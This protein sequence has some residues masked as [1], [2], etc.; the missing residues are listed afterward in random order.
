MTLRKR[1]GGG[2]APAGVRWGLLALLALLLGTLLALLFIPSPQVGVIRFSDLIWADSVTWLEAQFRYAEQDP[3]IRAIVIE[4]D[5]PGGE[6]AASERL[7]F[8]LLRLR[9]HKPVVVM[10][11]SMAASGGYYAAVAAD[12]IYATPSSDVGNIGVISTMPAPSFLVEDYLFTG[13]FK[14]FGSPRDSY[15]RQ[16]EVLKDTFIEGVFAQR[17]DRLAK[18]EVD[19][20]TLSRGEIYVG[21]L[22]LHMGL[23]DAIGSREDAIAHA[24]ELAQLRHYGVL[25]VTAEMSRTGQLPAYSM[26]LPQELISHLA[27]QRGSPGYFFLYLAPPVLGGVD[28][29]PA[30][31]GRTLKGGPR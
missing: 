30:P 7:Y 2:F 31:Y 9:T 20:A 5:S 24:A 22:G 21:A 27:G 6:A 23:V 25:D 11:N 1:V 19:R 14:A 26:Y 10:V 8:D 3:A 16:M 18:N 15:M 17:G 29:P 12:A 13:P 4:L 28:G